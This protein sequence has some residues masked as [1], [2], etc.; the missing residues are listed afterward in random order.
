MLALTVLKSKGMLTTL[1]VLFTE[2]TGGDGE[3]PQK[4]RAI[5]EAAVSTS[6]S[7]ENIVGLKAYMFSY[8]LLVFAP[9]I[10]AGMGLCCTSKVDL[11]AFFTHL[12]ALS[13][14]A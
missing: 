12:C 9:G 14:E 10:G 1:Q 11:K 6:M 4:A 5:L 7:H 13:I 8:R 3:L 2:R